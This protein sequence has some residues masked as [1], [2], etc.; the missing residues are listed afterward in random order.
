MEIC[1]FLENHAG[2]GLTLLRGI[3]AMIFMDI[4]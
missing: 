3:S 4:P 1:E 2:E